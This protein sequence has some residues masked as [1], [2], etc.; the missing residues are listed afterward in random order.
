MI[1]AMLP[2]SILLAAAILGYCAGAAALLTDALGQRAGLRRPALI[3]GALALL[4]H[5]GLLF[6]PQSSEPLSTDF[7]R[8]LSLVAWAMAVV[9]TAT[10]ARD[11][12]RVLLAFI[13]PVAA[14]AAALDGLTTNDSH[15]GVGDWQIRLH[16]V[17]ALSAYSVLAIAALQALVVAWQE[18]N[19]RRK[20]LAP[21]L[22]LL[23]P[24]SAMEDL[25]F[26]FIVAGFAL[27]TLTV[28]SGAL[29]IE[30]WMAQHLVHK[31]VLTIIAWVVYGVLV[32]GRWRFGWR[33][34]TAV[35]WTLSGMGVLLLAFFGSKF[36]LEILLGR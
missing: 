36:V 30:D 20:R 34:R 27:L 21:S 6:A 22:R 14:L 26:Q 13:W 12:S 18:H 25:L 3:A 15:G 24:L 2:T 19:L 31:T 35:R 33:G 9:M 8:A 7:F 17:I 23:P 5:T 4:A 10:H 11:R 32:Y 16:V 28:L 1:E 29:F